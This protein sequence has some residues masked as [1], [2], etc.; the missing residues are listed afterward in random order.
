[1]RYV[2]LVLMGYANTKYKL[3]VTIF[4][5]FCNFIYKVRVLWILH[6]ERL[7][8]GDFNV[9]VSPLPCPA[10]DPYDMNTV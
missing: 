8:F 5:V 3:I 1:M 9:L 7:V 2:H 4:L 6:I 10:V